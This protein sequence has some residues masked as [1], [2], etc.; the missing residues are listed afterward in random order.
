MIAANMVLN[1]VFNNWLS[2]ERTKCPSCN[3]FHNQQ[4]MVLFKMVHENQKKNNC[5]GIIRFSEVKLP[6]Q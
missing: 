2:M 3:A 6:N 4:T 1:K 5:H